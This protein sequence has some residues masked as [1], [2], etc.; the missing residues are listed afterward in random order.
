[1][2]VSPRTRQDGVPVRTCQTPVVVPHRQCSLI[3]SSL[4]LKAAATVG[5]CQ[6]PHSL[7]G[8]LLISTSTGAAYVGILMG[9]LCCLPRL[10]IRITWCAAVHVSAVPKSYTSFLKNS[11]HPWGSSIAALKNIIWFLLTERFSSCTIQRLFSSCE[12]ADALT[13]F[14]AVIC[15]CLFTC[16]SQVPLNK[17][18]RYQTLV[19]KWKLW[20]LLTACIQL[21]S[22]ASLTLVS[23]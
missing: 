19:L 12:L 2:T 23:L 4:F 1:M 18:P 9:G 16:I 21:N 3:V 20:C 5:P 15:T 22:R 14:I 13:L 10:W 11:N 7:R 17:Q 8:L 6:R